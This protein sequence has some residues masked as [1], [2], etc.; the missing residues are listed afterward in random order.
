MPKTK[1]APTQQLTLTKAPDASKAVGFRAD[2]ERLIVKDKATHKAALEM[3]GIGKGLSRVIEEH[4]RRFTRLVDTL[5]KDALALMRN[6]LDPVD[7][8]VQVLTR[9]ALDYEDR[10][11]ERVRIETEAQRKRDEAAAQLQRDNDLREA[12]ER[13][14][15]LEAASQDVSPKELWFIEKAFEQGIEVEARAAGL[16]QDDATTKAL[17]A[18][19][20]QAG[21]AN[22]VNALLRLEKSPKIHAA[23]R[24]K[25]EVKILRE[26]TN[27]LRQQPVEVITRAVET[28]TS[29]V[30]GVTRRENYSCV[31]EDP[32]ALRQAFL[33][34]KMLDPFA[35][36]PDATYLNAQARAIKDK[37]AFEAAYPG[38]T[39]VK[40]SGMAG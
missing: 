11:K 38:V 33:E 10:E 8:G 20:K 36:M 30:A 3:I 6:D 2:A 25:L 31:V 28:N 18:I 7:N 5:K 12:E 32:T 29:K 16:R 34:G 17:L 23:L 22:P 27:A 19:C 15:Q 1:D 40:T 14:S 4:H 9:K 39:F 21:Y 35:L 26:Q 37:A 13:E 24:A